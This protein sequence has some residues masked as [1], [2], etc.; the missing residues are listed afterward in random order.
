MKI[1]DILQ[2]LPTR[3]DL[4]HLVA[5]ETRSSGT[6]NMLTAFG[7]GILL[8]AGLAML[9]APK[10]G[11]EVRRDIG[12]RLGELGDQLQAQVSAPAAG[13]GAA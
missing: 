8:G 2:A 5:G 10:A 12:H 11:S 13:P 9:F 4:A 6:G 3:E 1:E 7:T